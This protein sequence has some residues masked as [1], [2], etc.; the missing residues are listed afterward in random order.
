ML[1]LGLLGMYFD[2]AVVF[3]TS[4]TFI[5]ISSCTILS[6]FYF[7]SSNLKNNFGLTTYHFHKILFRIHHKRRVFHQCGAGCVLPFCLSA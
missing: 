7:F 3:V 6:L 2:A 5:K 1:I 4:H